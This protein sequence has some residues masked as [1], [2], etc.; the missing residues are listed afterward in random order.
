MIELP[1]SDLAAIKEL[2]DRWIKAEL[3]RNIPELI[4]LCTDDVR[5]LPP[6]A[7]VLTGKDAV[8]E[9]LAGA[10]TAVKD[11]RIEDLIICGSGSLAYLTA[12]YHTQ[13]VL[14]SS[15]A[16][17]EVTGIHLWILQRAEHGT[18]RIEVMTWS[19]W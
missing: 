2:H 19:S 3:T 5:L 1:Q 16:V 14:S 13:F 7:P 17:H 6:A 18:W 8:A 12:R 15:E 11:I 9:F 10:E 4:E